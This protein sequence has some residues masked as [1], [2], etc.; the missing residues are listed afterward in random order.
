MVS[1]SRTEIIFVDTSLCVRVY[2]IH[3]NIAFPS[4]RTR[5]LCSVLSPFESCCLFFGLLGRPN[6][7]LPSRTFALGES[8][9]IQNF[10]TLDGIVNNKKLITNQVTG[11]PGIV[12]S[13]YDNSMLNTYVNGEYFDIINT[14]TILSI[15]LPQ[16]Q[17]NIDH[18]L[19]STGRATIHNQVMPL[20]EQELLKLLKEKVRFE[21]ILWTGEDGHA[22]STCQIFFNEKLIVEKSFDKDAGRDDGNI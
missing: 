12:V 16:L 19:N 5:I 1:D 18:H 21:V 3:E 20:I 6:D 13:T 10:N 22:G 11:G 4:G 15:D 8:F 7:W 2:L 14:Q 9:S 17:F